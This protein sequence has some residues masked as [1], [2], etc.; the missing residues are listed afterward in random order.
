MEIPIF[1]EL[2]TERRF[3]LLLEFCNFVENE[4]YD[5]AMCGSKRLYTLKPML[6]HDAKFG[7]IYTPECDVPV[8]ESLMM[9]KGCSS[10]KVYKKEKELR[11]L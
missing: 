10:W 2:Y 8:C 4:G 7:T 9:W 1:L 6:E 11:S 5:E 3:H